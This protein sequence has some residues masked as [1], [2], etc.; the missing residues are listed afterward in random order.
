MDICFF[1]STAAHLFSIDSFRKEFE[2]GVKDCRANLV[3]GP[4]IREFDS[5]DE[6]EISVGMLLLFSGQDM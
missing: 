1:E 5:K 3:K 2:K 6:I 4:V